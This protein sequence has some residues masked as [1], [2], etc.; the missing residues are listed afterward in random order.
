MHHLSFIP[1]F[2]LSNSVNGTERNAYPS[3]LNVLQVT[4]TNSLG[5]LVMMI[6]FLAL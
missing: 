5:R 2:A 3:L 4:M 6:P 1:N